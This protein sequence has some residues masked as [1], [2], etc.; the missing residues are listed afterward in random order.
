MQTSS[1]SVSDSVSPIR[2]YFFLSQFYFWFF[3]LVGG[4]AP[5][6]GL[7][8]D[9]QGYSHLEI[10]QLMSILMVTKVL[11]PNFWS[12]LGDRSQCRRRLVRWGAFLGGACFLLFFLGSGFWWFAFTMMA[13][14]FFWNAIL[15]QFEV[16]TLHNLAP[17]KSRY[18]RVRLWGS[19]G[20]IVSVFLLGAL[21]DRVSLN[22]LPLCLFFI[23][24]AIWISSLAPFSEPKSERAHSFS[25]LWTILK[26]S[27]T[28]AFFGINF[29]LQVSH[30][31]YYTFFSLYLEQFGFSNSRI[32]V[33]WAEGVIAEVV[34]FLVMHRLLERFGIR[35]LTMCALAITALRWQVTAMQGSE[36]W[37]MA[38]VQLAHA[39]SFGI[40]HS[41]AIQYVHETFSGVHEG[42]GQ[43]LYSA[44][45][46]GAGGAVG[47]I[48]CGLLADQAPLSQLFSASSVVSLGALL[49][50]FLFFSP[51]KEEKF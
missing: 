44:A 50:A 27:E 22:F 15:P 13:F 26:K 16:I 19:I 29:L 23:L 17:H 33:L 12:W 7:Y 18:S 1:S 31:A 25:G 9:S 39:A 46:F 11:A 10:G 2:T 20:F 5:Y 30:G 47:A 41:V 42:Q 49:I 24:C 36:F 34:V 40:M 37:V 35:R 8:L 51:G 43:A 3:A 32:G 21:F 45:S 48:L 4:M 14:S 28:C 38:F 6:W